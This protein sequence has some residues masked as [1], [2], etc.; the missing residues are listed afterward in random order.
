MKQ[1]STILA[2]ALLA[3][4]SASA[5]RTPEHP[6]DI[7]D[8]QWDNFAT[9][10]ENWTPGSLPGS[11]S[12][13]DDQ[14]YISRVRPLER[15]KDGDYQVHANVPAGRKMLM[16]TPLDDPTSTWKAL[17]RYCFEGDNFSM[18]Q[19]ITCH[20]NWTAPWVR[21]AGGLSDVAAKN[22][23]TV[24]CVMSIPWAA[25][26]N[27][28]AG[29]S[30]SI[31][32]NKLIEKNGDG[33]FKN[34]LK[35]AK[36]MKYYGI[37]GLG[38]NSEFSSNGNY[39]SQIMAFFADVHKKAASIGWKF[40]V[41]WYD[42][43]NAYGAITFDQGLGGH[44][45][46]IFGT[47]DKISVDQLFFNYNWYAS[48]L[49]K[50][51][52]KAQEMN[53][54]PFDLYAGFDIQG[55]AFKNSN[56]SALLSNDISIGF[57]G[58]HSQSLLHQSATDDGTSDIAIQKAYQQKLEY[59]F[60]GG[61]RNPGLLPSIATD[62]SL[63]NA[64]LKRFHGL[65]TFLTAKSTISQVPF[66][67]RF[68]LG[69]GLKFYK[70]GKV[71]FDSKWHNIN[72]QD[73][74]PTWRFWITDANDE[75]TEQSIGGLINAELS[76]DD[77]YSGG[78]SLMLSGATDFSRVKL[79]KTLLATEPSYELS[80]T[81]KLPAGTDPKAKLFVALKNDVKKYKE[82]ALPAATQGEW[83]TF[84]TTMQDLGLASGDEVAMIGLC[85]ENTPADYKMY[86][87]E[88]ALRNPSQTFAT[89]APTIK[90]VEVLRGR[91]T[92]ADFKIRY[93]S[94][95]ESNG[96][97]TYNDEVGTWY[98]DIYFQQ[99]G[100]EPQLLTSTTSWAAYVVGA[101]MTI[102]DRDCRFGVRA[103]S[104][105]GVQ[106]SEI[107]WTDYSEVAYDAQSTNIVIDRAVI[108]PGE[109]FKVYYEDVLA[110]AAQSWEIID[111][112]TGTTVA[113]AANATS[114]TT[115]IDKVGLYDVRVVA[116]N[117][118]ETVTR[119]FIQVSPESTGAVPQINGIT[120]NVKQANIEDN[121]EISYTSRDADGM[122]SRALKI[123]DPDMLS[124]PGET[125]VG[126]EYAIALWFKADGFTHDKQGTNL[127]SKNS[128]KDRWPHNN[129]GDL[130]VQVRPE[131]KSHPAN[132]IS[133]NVMG[134][135]EHDNPWESMMSTGYSVTPGVWNHL[136][137][138]Q[139]SA[140][141]QSM[142][143]NGKCVAGPITY[144][145]STR[146]ED[147]GKSDSRINYNYVANIYIGGGGVY[148]AGFNGAVDEVMVFNR[149]LSADEVIEAMKGYAPEN[150]P[151]GLQAYYT[152]E[153]VDGDGMFENFGAMK[154]CKAS[155][156]RIVDAGGESTNTA[157]YVQQDADNSLLGNPGITG[158]LDVTTTAEWSLGNA[159]IVKEE[160]KTVTVT[161]LG[162]GSK[163]V[164]LTLT[165]RWGSDTKEVADIV[166]I[167]DPS[168]VGS[169]EGNEFSVFPN[170]FVE[171]V[172][173][174]FAEAGAYTI[175]V[176]N[177]AGAL[178]QSVA[179]NAEAGQVAN[180]TVTGNKGLYV[181][182]VM[183]DGKLY[184]AVKVVK[185]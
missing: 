51:V 61:N 34:S 166:E 4:I 98:F 29:N 39:I 48:T 99:K 87:G 142:Y 132:E 108:K 175:N 12:D 25:N 120:A 65:A 145:N 107:T 62:C 73:F 9:L 109:T 151:S 19:Y 16:W 133:Y 92:S 78:S 41:Q 155:V 96:E 112:V 111:P 149:T 22:G 80:V 89:V 3:C 156:V 28:N 31:T 168:S 95:A 43:T 6:L 147:L 105:D 76:W 114:V 94:K 152:F 18:W 68:G 110:D 14:F 136:V 86:V 64:D 40:E 36:F 119:G 75:V 97:K 174:R 170:P 90:E 184:K 129:W 134:W 161:F 20:G 115:S 71:A 37:N 56:W 117:G 116:A 180:V 82:V 154:E 79:F 140:N 141:V 74:L 163:T 101:P 81:Y 45:A 30:Y 44:N 144:P 123:T 55:R 10:F 46:G 1:R 137:I 24:G 11:V 26:V 50:S 139:T 27:A 113:S 167:I 8:A 21:V 32:F 83:T 182:Q 85:L 178:V 125:Q 146:R 7:Q 63:G 179:A 176:V 2:A 126:K 103:V 70:E 169:I 173:F 118:E 77:A 88:I 13:M 157:S 172:N 158:T 49:S 102:G 72:M 100:E 58:A 153:E 69:N 124:I 138:Q 122:V 181:V 93:E 131:Y 135:T 15:I 54:D 130:W 35:L 23:V 127:I 59:T 5:Q 42:G 52:T 57:W 150:V 165:N 106:A 60:S 164:G 159:S 38:V 91:A 84:K 53:R 148:K 143:L 160:G 67:S 128:I 121:V 33:T 177:E 183:K 104:P 185:K 17:P 47:G 171:S 66:V 162:A